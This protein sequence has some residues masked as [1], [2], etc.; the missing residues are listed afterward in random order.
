[1]VWD[2]SDADVLSRGRLR[3]P[4]PLRAGRSVSAVAPVLNRAKRSP[5]RWL[6]LV[7]LLRLQRRYDSCSDL[8]LL[9]RCGHIPVRL[10][11]RAAPGR[12]QL[13]PP[14]RT[15]REAKRPTVKTGAGGSCRLPVSG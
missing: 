1:M 8:Q 9:C 5:S 3:C 7:N 10:G 14:R 11:P 13:S 15:P 6:L 2:L 12:E 4:D